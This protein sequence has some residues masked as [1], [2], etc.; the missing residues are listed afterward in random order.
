[1]VLFPQ[2]QTKGFVL[3]MGTSP[4]VYYLFWNKP[5]AVAPWN[6]TQ[7]GYDAANWIQQFIDTW[8]TP[9]PMI[10]AGAYGIPYPYQPDWPNTEFLINEAFNATVKG[11][12]SRYCTHLYALADGSSLAADMSHMQTA[13][14]VSLLVPKVAAAK[15]VNRPYILGETGFHG[16]DIAADATFGGALQIL[17]KTL[18]ATS[19]GIERLFY[20]QGTINQGMWISLPCF[21]TPIYLTWNPTFPTFPSPPFLVFGLFRS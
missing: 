4:K 5:V 17:D 13:A 9:L 3:T 1:M 8:K 11:A 15:S 14:D 19:V 21:H 20:H 16:Q 10:S 12:V 2:K 7:E 6:E 18:R